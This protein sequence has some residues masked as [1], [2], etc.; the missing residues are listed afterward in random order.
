V[1]VF[2]PQDKIEEL[3]KPDFKPQPNASLKIHPDDLDKG[4]GVPQERTLTFELPEGVRVSKEDQARRVMFR[5]EKL[6]AS[7]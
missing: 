3:H 5:L 6:V 7:E 4:L 1:T 2:G